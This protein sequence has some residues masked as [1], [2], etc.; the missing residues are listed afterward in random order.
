MARLCVAFLTDSDSAISSNSPREEPDESPHS[1]S[2]SPIEFRLEL[3]TV[4]SKY[5][6]SLSLRSSSRPSG[7]LCSLRSA[8]SA[9]EKIVFMLIIIQDS[10]ANMFDVL[11]VLQDV[12]VVSDSRL[13]I[14]NAPDSKVDEDNISIGGAGFYGKLYMISK[15]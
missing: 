2:S 11:R 15:Y 5:S 6:S 13:L 10:G 4:C 1:L 12:V 14:F 9:A 3:D 7:R 8:V